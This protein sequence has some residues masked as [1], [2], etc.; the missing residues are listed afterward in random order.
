[1]SGAM[2]GENVTGEMIAPGQQRHFQLDTQ[3]QPF[4]AMT[5]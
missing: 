5:T 1:M 2:F 3:R 4:T